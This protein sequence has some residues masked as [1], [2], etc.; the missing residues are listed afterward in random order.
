MVA[1]LI[2]LLLWTLLEYFLHR[3]A[4]HR[5]GTVLRSTHPSHHASPRDLRFLFAQPLLVVGSSGILIGALWL[6]TGDWVT[7][8]E[9]MAGIW[10]GYLYYESVHYRIHFADRAGWCLRRQRRAHFRHHFDNPRRGFG[11]T[12]PLWDWVFRTTTSE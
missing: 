4:F 10:A 11:V 8:I 3:Y 7:T 6:L 2:G 9:V 1:V 5:F 12:S